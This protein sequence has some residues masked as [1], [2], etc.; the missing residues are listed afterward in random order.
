MSSIPAN[1][2]TTTPIIHTIYTT[3]IPVL[4]AL[5]R[6]VI[7]QYQTQSHLRSQW[8]KHLRDPTND[9]VPEKKMCRETDMDI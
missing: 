8:H 3:N 1:T 4:T 7:G 5:R 9:Y 2:T 6:P